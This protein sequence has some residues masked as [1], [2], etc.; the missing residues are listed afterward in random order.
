[1][2]LPEDTAPH[3]FIV[4]VWTDPAVPSPGIA[5]GL[6]EHVPTRERRY[7]RTLAEMEDFVASRLSISHQAGKER[8]SG[9]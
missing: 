4:R 6:I 5:R 2:A 9:P 8:R 3:L 7:F 1:L